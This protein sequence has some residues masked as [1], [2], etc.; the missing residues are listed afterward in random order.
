MCRKSIYLISFVL[1]LVLVLLLPSAGE[2]GDSNIMGW[3]KFDGDALD[4]SGNERHGTLHGSPTFGPGVFGQALEFQPNPDYVTID[5]YKG[6]LGTHAFSITAWVKTTNTAT[7]QITHWGTH[8]DGQRVEFRIQSNRLRISGGGGN[9]QGNTD[10]IDGQ[11]HHVVAAVI[12]NASA[13]SGDATFYVDG[14]EDTIASTATVRWDIVANATLDVTIGYRPTQ[15]DRPFIGSIDDVL[16]Y[17]KVLTPEEVA[18]VINGEILPVSALASN[19]NP[20]NEQTDVLREVVLSWTSGEYVGALSPKHKVFLSENFNDVN[21]GV[22]GVTQD[23]NSYAPSPRLDF[24]KT[25]YWRVDEAN[26]TTGWDRGE[27]WQFATEP[28]GYAIGNVTATASSAHQADMGP[29]NSINGSGLDANDLHSAETTDMWLSSTEPLGSWI[30]FQFDKVYKL[31]QMWVW[32]SNQMVES[33]VGMGFKNVTIEYSTNGTDYTTLG[34][35]HE[36]AQAPGTPDYEHNTTV[37]FGALTAKYVRLTANSNWGGLMPQYGLSEVRFFYIPVRAREPNPASGATDVDV[38]VTL[39]FRAGREAAQHDV[40]FGSDEQAVIDGNAPVTTVPE[41]SYGPL[42]LDLAQTYYWKINEVNMAETPTT[43]EGDVWN[44]T[45]REFLVVDNFESYNDL[46]PDDPESNRIFNVWLD[47]YEQPANGC[48]VGYDQPPFTEQNIVHGG[49]QA[50]PLAYSNT[51]GAA[52]SEAELTLSPSQDW[53]KAGATT[54]VLYFH[55]TEG[56]TGQLYVKVNGTKIV[57]DG[58]AGNLALAGWQ[59]W[60][61][62]L[63]SVGTNLQNVTTL[64]IGIDGNGASGTLYVDDI[65]LYASA[66]APPNEWRVADDADDVEEAVA[67]GSMDM[68]SSDLELPYENTGQGNPQIIG[69]RFTGIPIPKGA[70]ITD[71]WVRFQVDEAKGGT[72]PVNLIIEG[73]L[74]A[75][76][77]GFTSDAFNVSS[78]SRT[79][80]Q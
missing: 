37:D 80:A 1:V 35:T 32:N 31:H 14:R 11:W 17:D 61:I 58:N 79:T 9:V 77:A 7:Q 34:T 36:F 20:A 47:G 62:D 55:G 26:N 72:E 50:M 45:T 24:G 5:G 67:T 74:S 51:A 46:D 63:A 48:L 65:G 30:E 23:A 33:L 15:A 75:N 28:V 53:T 41:T 64:S 16:I 66:P 40:Y 3:W 8:S 4:S 76:A 38:D 57:Y 49:E 59:V 56:N 71:A 73:E 60:N 44:L 25:Y 12:E 6:V 54:L 70:T 69:V 39:S 43:L 52:Y 29:E 78:R 2:A 42:S 18:L 27:L 19:P 22:G 21:D 13:S 68:T 10:L